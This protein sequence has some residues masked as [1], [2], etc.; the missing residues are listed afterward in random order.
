MLCLFLFCSFWPPEDDVCDSII[1]STGRKFFCQAPKLCSPVSLKK[2]GACFPQTHFGSDSENWWPDCV[3]VTSLSGFWVQII[4]DGG[5]DLLLQPLLTSWW[6]TESDCWQTGSSSVWRLRSS[7]ASGGRFPRAVRWRTGPPGTSGTWS[8][9]PL[10][11]LEDPELRLR[12]RS[13]TELT[14][15]DLCSNVSLLR[16][17]FSRS[18]GR[19]SSNDNRNVFDQINLFW[20]NLHKLKQA[21]EVLFHNEGTLITFLKGVRQLDL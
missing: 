6:R 7:W 10:P 1:F 21:H 16:F 15:E 8:K 12:Q 19:S 4:T 13:N 14:S 9:E 11:V 18:A 17:Y 20:T 2:C 3:C 5:S